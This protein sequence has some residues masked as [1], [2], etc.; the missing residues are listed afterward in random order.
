[1]PCKYA[2]T[3]MRSLVPWTPVAASCGSA[4][5]GLHRRQVSQICS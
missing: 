2:R 3:G 1:M 5:K 4:M